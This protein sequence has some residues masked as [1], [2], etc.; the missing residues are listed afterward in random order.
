MDF[1]SL[2]KTVGRAQVTDNLN[3]NTG[4][5]TEKYQQQKEMLD[6]EVLL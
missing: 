5:L 3:T 6:V 1:T 2:Q 4:P